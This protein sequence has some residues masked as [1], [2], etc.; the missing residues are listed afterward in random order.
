[1]IPGGVVPTLKIFGIHIEEPWSGLHIWIIT[2][3]QLPVVP[4]TN[5]LA[6]I[7]TG[8]PWSKGRFDRFRKVWISVFDGVKCQ[9]SLGINDKWFADGIRGAG[10]NAS[11]TS[12]TKTGCWSIR[13]EGFCCE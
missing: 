4:R 5:V 7:A 3:G 13:F 6:N 1:L 8:D 11:D 10:I 2:A 9:A 12:A